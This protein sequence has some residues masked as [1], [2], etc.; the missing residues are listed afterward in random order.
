MTRLFSIKNLNL[1]TSVSVRWASP[2]SLYYDLDL[3]S[4]TLSTGWAVS[5]DAMTSYYL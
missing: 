1:I 4:Y 5:H 3:L 2:F